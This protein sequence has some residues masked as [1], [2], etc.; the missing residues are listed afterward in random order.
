MRKSEAALCHRLI[1]VLHGAISQKK[2]SNIVQCCFEN[3]L[4]DQL[5]IYVNLFTYI[6]EIAICSFSTK[7][8]PID[9]YV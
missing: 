3:Y 4:A 6:Y 9:L 8:S 1:N 2:T 7:F 5:V